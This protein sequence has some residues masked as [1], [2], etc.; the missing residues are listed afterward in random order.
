MKTTALFALA[1]PLVAACSSSSTPLGTRDAAKDVATDAGVEASPC[2]DDL[3]NDCTMP[4]PSYK[5][6]IVPILRMRCAPCHFEGGVEDFMIDFSTWANVDNA[7][8]SIQNQLFLCDMP[9]VF[10]IPKLGVKPA[11]ALSDTQR[12]T[13]Y[14]WLR[15]GA[16]DN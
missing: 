9:P 2:K 8:V 3:T 12:K 11:P 6:D 1:L 7:D 4:S 15:C 16:L 13:L 14:D 5:D 10:G